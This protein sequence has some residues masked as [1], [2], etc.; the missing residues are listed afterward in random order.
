MEEH[1]SLE[2]EK[3]QE[4]RYGHGQKEEEEEEL[5]SFAFALEEDPYGN[6]QLSGFNRE[7]PTAKDVKYRSSEQQLLS[8][9]KLGS[10]E[11][12][13]RLQKAVFGICNDEPA[14]LV[15]IKVDLA[16]KSK[17]FFRFRRATLEIEVEEPPTGPNG[18]EFD[19]DDDDD[20][21]T[22]AEYVGPLIHRF[23]P[24]LIRGHIQTAAE[25]YKISFEMPIPSPVP[26][27]GASA[28]WS[29]NSPREGQHLIQ[30]FLVGNPATRVK[31]NMNE[32]EV[33]K[34][35]LFEQPTFAV[36]VRYRE[37]RGFTLGL[38]LRATTY[39]GLAVVGKGVSRIKFFKTNVGGKDEN[40]ARRLNGLS[41]GSVAVS[42]K[43]WGGDAVSQSGPANLQ[44]VDLEY[45]TQMRATLLGGQGPG[46]SHLG[47]SG[48]EAERQTHFAG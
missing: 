2:Q 38:R 23:Y 27:G 18:E 25:M 8:E 7:K 47:R 30:G 26:I 48:P 39:G 13:A 22:D 44:E 17:G 41:G 3:E 32:N 9:G 29:I 11:I 24:D 31:W 34:S 46:A 5:P 1:A 37:E 28:G 10:S 45:L 21:N 40:R 19:D 16:S 33:S 20:D 35:G 12:A 36:V 14:C 15:I 43:T 42:G 4:L 6:S